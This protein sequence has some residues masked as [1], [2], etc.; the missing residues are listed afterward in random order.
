MFQGNLCCEARKEI[1]WLTFSMKSQIYAQQVL[2][3]PSTPPSLR[4]LAVTT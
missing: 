2:V 1:H 4:Y 3:T